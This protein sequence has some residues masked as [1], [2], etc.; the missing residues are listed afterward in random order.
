MDVFHLV[1]DTSMLRKLPFQHADFKRLLIRS[2]MGSLRICIPKI[3]LEEERTAQ[4]VK[5]IKA[6]IADDSATHDK[7][8]AEVIRG[9]KYD[10][11]LAW[12]RG[13]RLQAV[14]P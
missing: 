11:P 8:G 4:L 10:T 5:H 2:Q 3:V 13:P 14:G 9:R 1:I 7:S 12:R 6:S